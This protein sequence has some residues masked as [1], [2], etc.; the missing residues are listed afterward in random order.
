MYEAVFSCNTVLD[1][2]VGG[3]L[4]VVMGSTCRRGC[5]DER[6]SAEMSRPA[7]IYLHA[8][9]RDGH[10]WCPS[11]WKMTSALAPTME[12]SLNHSVG[13]KKRGRGGGCLVVFTPQ[14]IACLLNSTRQMPGSTLT[15]SLTTLRTPSWVFQPNPVVCFVLYF[16]TLW[17]LS[18]FS[19]LWFFLPLFLM[20]FSFSPPNWHLSYYFQKQ[21]PLKSDPLSP[22]RFSFVFIIPPNT[23][24]RG[25]PKPH[26]EYKKERK[27][28]TQERAYEKTLFFCF[29]QLK[30]WQQ[31]WFQR[32]ISRA[33][34]YLEMLALGIRE[35]SLCTRPAAR[36]RAKTRLLAVRQMHP[37]TMARCYRLVKPVRSFGHTL[38]KRRKPH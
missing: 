15:S 6:R 38:K 34:G 25:R 28:K 5:T 31:K 9:G 1:C 27:R 30:N 21:P 7:A 20:S 26:C 24:I 29:V 22:S 16:C 23:P 14:L 33:A 3:R 10:V 18:R 13:G 36:W 12:S 37:R 19:T 11:R 4:H 17:S 32:R 8:W 2:T 35:P